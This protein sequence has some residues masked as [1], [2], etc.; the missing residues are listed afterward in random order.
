MHFLS[1][2]FP[3]FL[4]SFSPILSFLSFYSFVRSFFLP[5]LRN[6]PTAF[7]DKSNPRR[8]H[9]Q[10]I[11]RKGERNVVYVGPFETKKKVL[12]QPFFVSLMLPTGH[13]HCSWIDSLRSFVR[14]Y[15]LQ[16]LC[17]LMLSTELDFFPF[18]FFTSEEGEHITLARFINGN[19]VTT[20][21]FL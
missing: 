16:F 13:I 2:S 5:F 12:G 15:R 7:S 21:L 1:F 9:F 19:H 14:H 4:F 6:D 3:L 17:S 18:D 10:L 11:E 20:T 8:R